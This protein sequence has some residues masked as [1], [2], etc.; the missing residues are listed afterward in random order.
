M[1]IISFCLFGSHPKYL[2]GAIKN[3]DLAASIFPD[4][5][6]RFYCS[7]DVGSKTLSELA[8]RP[9]VELFLNPTGFKNSWDLMLA[10]FMPINE[11]DVEVMISRDCDSR[12]SLRERYAVDAWL[13]S[14]YMFHTM[15]DHPWHTV[16][17]LGGMFG[18]KKKLFSE[19]GYH[20][21]EWAKNHEPKWQVDQD[22]L[23]E[24]VWPIVKHDNLNH[25][26]FFTHLFGGVP[27]P[28]NR[29]GLEFVGQVYD[30][31]DQPNQEYE[32]VLYKYLKMHGEIVNDS[33]LFG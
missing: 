5:Y 14:K 33:P 28:K 4:W 15:H 1:K 17:I 32:Y 2:V 13:D 8:T 24:V 23:K 3:A 21:V 10:R 22:F 26:Q 29:E 12:L 19:L 11:D 20:A 27:F 18:I 7:T 25:D 30:A 31:N 16:P 9:N 6:C